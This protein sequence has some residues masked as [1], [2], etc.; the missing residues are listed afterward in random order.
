[1][2]DD[3]KLGT[4]SRASLATLALASTFVTAGTHA[5]PGS[6]VAGAGEPRH[7]QTG[8]SCQDLG[9]A[10]LD[11]RDG[12]QPLQVGLDWGQAFGDG[13]TETLA[14]LVQH[15]DVRSVHGQQQTMVVGQ[16]PAEGLFAS[17]SMGLALYTR[18]YG[19]NRHFLPAVCSVSTLRTLA[20]T[21][22]RRDN[23]G[24][25]E[26]PATPV[27]EKLGQCSDCVAGCDGALL[28]DAEGFDLVAALGKA[29]A[30]Q[31]LNLKNL[32]IK[33]PFVGKIG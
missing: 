11:S 13:L 20:A 32:N 23:V 26:L 33:Q 22:S 29:P 7:L 17:N 14:R 10:A 16:P 4:C 19:T 12:L 1:M 8:L 15:V 3:T 30:L 18:I 2:F 21:T 5:S 25:T 9:G 27:A 6:Q 28:G 31:G 24:Q